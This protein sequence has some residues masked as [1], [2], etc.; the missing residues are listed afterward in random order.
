MVDHI[1]NTQQHILTI[2][3]PIEF[4]HTPKQCLINQR[5]VHRDTASFSR[6]LRAALREDPDVI[7]VGELDL[8]TIRLALEA[9]ETGHVVFATLHTNRPPKPSIA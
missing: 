8:E 6:A 1:N 5:E 7:M 9:A 2:E 4:V 3:D